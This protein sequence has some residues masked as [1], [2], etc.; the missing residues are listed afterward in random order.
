MGGVMQQF[1][2]GRTPP[3]N[4]RDEAGRLGIL[5][6]KLRSLHHTVHKLS[7]QIDSSG[8]NKCLVPRLPTASRP[9]LPDGQIFRP[10]GVRPPHP[11]A[12]RSHTQE[13]KTA[14]AMGLFGTLSQ[15]L[16]SFNTK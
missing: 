1:I 15:R 8:P 12:S 9:M 10:T 5:S 7:A 4:L 16:K 2:S 14:E 3:M 13:A 6:S 11:L